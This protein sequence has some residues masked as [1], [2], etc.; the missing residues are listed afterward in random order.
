MHA[1]ALFLQCFEDCCIE[2]FV[3]SDSIEW[4]QLQVALLCLINCHV[5]TRTSVPET[6][7]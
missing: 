2:N 1:T 7:P 5:V 3:H 4:F 6:A